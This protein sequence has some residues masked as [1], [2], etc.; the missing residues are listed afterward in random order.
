MARVNRYLHRI[1]AV[2]MDTCN[3]GQEEETVDHFLF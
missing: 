3:D 2:E 1:G